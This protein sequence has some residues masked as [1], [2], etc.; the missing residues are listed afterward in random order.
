M[1]HYSDTPPTSETHLQAALAKHLDWRGAACFFNSHLFGWEAD[2]YTVSGSGYLREYEIKVDWGDWC[3]DANKSKFSAA[4]DIQS[5][6]KHIKEFWYVVPQALYEAKGLPPNL[7][8]G[9]G[10]LVAAAHKHRTHFTVVVPATTNTNAVALGHHHLRSLYRS[11]YYKYMYTRLKA[12]PGPTLELY[13]PEPPKK[14]K[15]VTA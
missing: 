3:R 1:I 6:A 13:Y 5:R 4:G 11:V 15:V 8:P 7:P 14:P 10:V 2:V 9:S 12:A